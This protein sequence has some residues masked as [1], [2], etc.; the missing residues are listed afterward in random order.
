MAIGVS[1]A[2]T[3]TSEGV[4]KVGGGGGLGGSRG[5][6][7]PCSANILL[8]PTAGRSWTSSWILK[9]APRSCLVNLS[10]KYHLRPHVLPRSHVEGASVLPR[11]VIVIF[12]GIQVGLVSQIPR[13]FPEHF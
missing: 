11:G 9:V 5:P 1:R 8:G 4:V 7:G 10:G 13:L 12:R 3:L 6:E 2:A